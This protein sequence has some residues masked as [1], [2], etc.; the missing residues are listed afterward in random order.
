MTLHYEYEQN[1]L[2]GESNLNEALLWLLPTAPFRCFDLGLSSE[3]MDSIGSLEVENSKQYDNYGN[4]K[5]LESEL[6]HFFSTISIKNVEISSKVAHIVNDL[7]AKILLATNKN[8]AHVRVQTSLNYGDNSNDVDYRTGWHIDG[9]QYLSDMPI[10][11]F[12]YSPKGDG[13]KFYP[14]D[15]RVFE[16]EDEYSTNAREYK[17]K[18]D[19]INAGS[20]LKVINLNKEFSCTNA[21]MAVMLPGHCPHRVPTTSEDRIFISIEPGTEEEIKYLIENE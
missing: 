13:T 17:D 19:A 3:N 18:N 14:M 5:N 20:S 9:D 8:D 16:R 6:E 11:K 1:S 12:V 7:V 15:E 10:Y 21:Q 4:L 2:C